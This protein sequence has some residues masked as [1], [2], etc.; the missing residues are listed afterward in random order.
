[1]N[2]IYRTVWSESRQS[3]VVA[4]EKAAPRG[5]P[6]S[7]R[8]AIVS[9]VAAALVALAGEGMASSCGNPGTT[10][11]PGAETDRCILVNGES[12]SVT[13]SIVN[14][15]V[16]LGEV[17]VYV[18]AGV[19]TAG[20]IH[21][22]GGTIAGMSGVNVAGPSAILTGGLTN[23]G[24]ISGL[25]AVIVDLGG[26]LQ[27]GLTN[28]GTIAGVNIG[29]FLSGSSTLSGNL[30]N[31]ASG[32]IT[33]STGT[34]IVLQAGSRL[35]GSVINE[36]TI[37]APASLAIALRGGSQIDNGITNSAQITASHGIFVMSNST[38]S[39]GVTNDGT[40]TGFS[41]GINFSSQSTLA[42]GLTNTVSV[43][44]DDRGINISDSS[45]IDYI[46]NAANAY[47]GASLIAIYLANSSTIAAGITNAGTISGL[48]GNAVKVIG[49]STVTDGITNNGT[50]SSFNS[51][52]I[53]VTDG[54]T[55]AGV[56]NTGL[57]S[58]HRVGMQIDDA[59]VG[60]IIN[61]TRVSSG[62]TYVGTISGDE[63]G[64]TISNSA[65][66]HSITNSGRISYSASSNNTFG[67]IYVG[68]A[69]VSG[70][71]NNSGTISGLNTS[72]SYALGLWLEGAT[73]GSITNSGTISAENTYNADSA[74]G[75]W[76][77]YGS[78]IS[79]GITNSGL[80]SGGYGLEIDSSTLVGGIHNDGGRII[81]TASSGLLVAFSSTV[82]GGISNSGT[83]SGGTHG[84]VVVGSTISDG[85]FNNGATST[86]SGAS[87]AGL[88]IT[89][90]SAVTGGLTNSG[91]I[92]GGTKAIYVDGSS[93]LDNIVIAGNDTAKFIGEVFAEDTPVTVA[94]GATYT[95]DDGQ[96]FTLTNSSFTNAG[97]LK[98]GAGNTGTITGDFVNTGTFSSTITDTAAGRLVVSGTANLGGQLAVDASLMTGGHSH[99]SS[100]A[101]V[102]SAGAVNGTFAGYSDN[103]ALFDFTPTYTATTVDLTIVAAGSGGGGGGGSTGVLA[104]TKPPGTTRRRVRP[105]CSTT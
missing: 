91:T 32:N 1:M 72:S 105:G 68:N 59:T 55:V 95:M 100:I 15:S 73:V 3:Y 53:L 71:I 87:G 88:R 57:I 2:K 35:T 36:G 90:T 85:I 45:Q 33:A 51:E 38:L 54:S 6:S 17:G 86:I 93:S 58:G 74:V 47:I 103:S 76:I 84:I 19:S 44:G 48:N 62:T 21:N 25:G 29:I 12:L 69:T 23:S 78:S 4:H 27:S 26:Q 81:G 20:S 66:V 28:S 16:G 22:D 31:A 40:I 7:T 63:G 104:A 11:I 18:G 52:G 98:V 8:K 99:G 92:S 37:S 13:G 50:I 70:A 39:G 41:V 96:L 24:S 10:V 97:T 101:G 82:S 14:S 30:I 34:A 46:S 60:P 9:V 94:S 5:K 64:I 80:I 49:N 75:I 89:S 56:T 77:K 61:T 65:V 42:G 79:A 67:A 102:V 43:S 83:I